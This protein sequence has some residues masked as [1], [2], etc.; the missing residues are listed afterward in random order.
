MI[1]FRLQLFFLKDY[2]KLAHFLTD[3]GC[4]EPAGNRY[5]GRTLAGNVICR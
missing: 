4:A 5:L 3:D 2:H 1:S